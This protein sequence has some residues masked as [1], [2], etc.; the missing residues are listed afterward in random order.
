MA[1]GL[2]ELSTGQKATVSLGWFAMV[3]G[4][5]LGVGTLYYSVVSLS[6]GSPEFTAVLLFIG[7][8]F[9]TTLMVSGLRLR[10]GSGPARL[11]V[12]WGATTGARRKAADVIGW[13]AMVCG[14]LLG[15]WSIYN[16]ATRP[17]LNELDVIDLL[18]GLAIAVTLVVISIRLWQRRSPWR[19]FLLGFAVSLALFVQALRVAF[20]TF[21]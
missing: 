3:V 7:G 12:P 5:L 11:E 6:A 14:V 21:N 13:L 4:T 8:V 15:S 1:R 20:R 16:A 9:A 19:V 17:K 18:L 10:R 2:G